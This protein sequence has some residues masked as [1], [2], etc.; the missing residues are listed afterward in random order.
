MSLRW[1]AHAVHGNK[2]ARSAYEMRI[3]ED[4]V[5]IRTCAPKSAS[6][7][8]VDTRRNIYILNIYELLLV[9]IV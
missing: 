6:R 7:R 8:Y 3:T 2:S 4:E 5:D 1:M 9:S